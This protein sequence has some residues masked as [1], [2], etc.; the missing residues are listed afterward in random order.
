MKQITL[1]LSAIRDVLREGQVGYICHAIKVLIA[2]HNGIPDWRGIPEAPTS[3]VLANLH[4]LFPEYI[5]HPDDTPFQVLDGWMKWGA[6]VEVPELRKV[7][8]QE[9]ISIRDKEFRV[10]LLTHWIDTNGDAEMNFVI[11]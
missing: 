5:M 3:E 7:A 4:K 6:I 2:E 9:F 11:R 10:N 8:R 1:T